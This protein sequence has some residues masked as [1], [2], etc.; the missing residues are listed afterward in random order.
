MELD[1]P[2][3]FYELTAEDLQR[4]QAQAAAKRKVGASLAAM[5]ADDRLALSDLAATCKVGTYLAVRRRLPVHA[6]Y[7]D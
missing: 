5:I 2:D 4:L 3:E 7:E 1:P 6:W